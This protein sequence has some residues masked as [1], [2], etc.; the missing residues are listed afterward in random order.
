M[1]LDTNSAGLGIELELTSPSDVELDSAQNRLLVLNAGCYAPAEGGSQHLRHGVEIV[2]LATG[3]KSQPYQAS[4]QDF[5]G[6]L[7][8]LA[9]DQALIQRFDVNFGTHWNNWT[10]GSSTLGTELSGVPSAA[11]LR[12]RR[13]PDRHL[14][15]DERCGRQQRGRSLRAQR[16]DHDHDR[17]LALEH[18]LRGQRR[19]S[20]R[21]L[22]HPQVG[23]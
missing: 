3:T 2:A 22:T 12:W 18:E 19:D 7:V 9:G 5:L 1:D 15:H 13:Q 10:I 21:A 4:N 8:L 14:D 23:A 17:K 11:E 20:A 6:R 16:W